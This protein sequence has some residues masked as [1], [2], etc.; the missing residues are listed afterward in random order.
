MDRNLPIYP[1]KDEIVASIEEYPITI[2]TAE[3]GSGKSTQVCQYLYE[4]GYDVVVTEP[5]RLAAVTLAARVESEMGAEASKGLV[6][7]HTGFES[8]ETPTTRILFATDGLQLIR[9]LTRRKTSNTKVLIIDEVHEWNLNQEMLVAW[10]NHQLS[11]GENLKVVIMSAT[12]ESAKLQEYFDVLSNIIRIP[13]RLYPVTAHELRAS[14]LI[15]VIRDRASAGKNVLVFAAGKPEINQI[16]DELR[17][18]GATARVLPL[19]GELSMEQQRA[20]FMQYS[21]NKIIVSTNVAQTSVTVPD[22]DCVIDTGLEKRTDCID[23]VQGLFM[24]PISQADI[25]QRRGRA[26]RTG[27]GEYYLCSNDSIESREEFSTAEIQRSLL[28][29][30]VLRLVSVGLDPEKLKFFHQPDKKSLRKAFELLTKLGAIEDGTITDIGKEMSKLPVSAR[31]AKMLFEADKRGV[32]DSMLTLTAILEVGSP[33]SN[34][35]G[36]GWSVTLK[37]KSDII[38][39]LRS[40]K[41]IESFKSKDLIESGFNAKRVYRIRDLEQKLRAIISQNFDVLD[42]G[43]PSEI[44]RRVT[45]CYIA[46]MIDTLC[47][48]MGDSVRD[49]HDGFYRLD[50]K[51]VCTSRYGQIFVGMPRI[52]ECKSH[53]GI[54]TTLELLSM[55]APV[56]AEYLLE[57]Y[58]KFITL[59]VDMFDSFYDGNAEKCVVTELIKFSG[60]AIGKH[61]RDVLEGDSLYQEEYKELKS[62]YEEAL[63]HNSVC[64]FAS[65]GALSYGEYRDSIAASLSE[66]SVSIEGRNFKYSKD[67]RGSSTTIYLS[68][69]EL[70]SL[71]NTTT[72]KLPTG[73]G[74]TFKCHG[75]HSMN[76]NDLRKK[77]REELVSEAKQ[78][79]AN[80]LPKEFTLK[81]SGIRT[82]LESVGMRKIPVLDE[83]IQ[84]FVGLHLRDKR[85]GVS[86]YDTQEASDEGTKEA[87]Q[88]LILNEVSTKYGEK[89]FK[90]TCNGKSTVTKKCERAREEFMTFV[91]DCLQEVTAESYWETLDLISE[92]FEECHSALVA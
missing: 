39:E 76:L 71:M 18:Q 9:S 16:M 17:I 47:V 58:R 60:L 12:L 15:P 45:E 68:V 55:V 63:R 67:W 19:H 38:A 50:R 2:L 1:L 91:Q 14:A 37:C 59:E 83:D 81:S 25:A 8:T 20:C 88:F 46:G 74:I 82:L 51:S 32:L 21:S 6:A 75:R 57:N 24:H 43:T 3:T 26:G 72:C 69:E 78:D 77:V 4:A 36:Y 22:I 79:V 33:I 61:I 7:Y 85:V 80:S 84:V 66:C 53:W 40:W 10:I 92:F 31:Y 90:V 54:P 27:P 28:D 42:C 23:G 35:S 5:R 65:L 48:S 44:E 49:I 89:K 11:N 87:L 41:K 13:G 64:S 73:G 29:Q 34:E 70:F 30:V 62:R 86:T 56:D 52:I